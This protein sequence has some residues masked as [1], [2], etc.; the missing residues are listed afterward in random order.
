[1]NVYGRAFC[2]RTTERMDVVAVQPRKTTTQMNVCGRAFCHRI[3]ERM[4]VVAV[5]LGRIM[6]QMNACGRV[7]YHRIT[8]RVGG[9]VVQPIKTTVRRMRTI[10]FFYFVRTK[11]R[12]MTLCINMHYAREQIHEKR[13][14]QAKACK[15]E[16]E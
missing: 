11:K 10:V 14:I 9:V 8:E 15:T 5:Q 12:L 16:N 3:T 6:T 7:F 1:M 4:D 2:H 13:R